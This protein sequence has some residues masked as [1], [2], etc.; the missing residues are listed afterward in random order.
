MCAYLTFYE[1][2]SYWYRL[3]LVA[4][5]WPTTG[6]LFVLIAQYGFADFPGV[7]QLAD[8]QS[9]LHSKLLTSETLRGLISYHRC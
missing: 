8:C 7:H 9:H 5:T 4:L 6:R 1:L 3:L 2:T